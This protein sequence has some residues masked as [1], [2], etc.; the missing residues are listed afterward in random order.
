MSTNV[1]HI[2]KFCDPSVCCIQ[3]LEAAY[4]RVTVSLLVKRDSASHNRVSK[5]I[6]GFAAAA[7]MFRPR[8]SS[9][10]GGEECETKSVLVFKEISLTELHHD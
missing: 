9:G 6:S 1:D 2:L 10:D 5:T 8:K 7:Y 3:L 4:H